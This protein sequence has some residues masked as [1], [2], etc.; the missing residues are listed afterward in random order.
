MAGPWS[1]CFLH[2]ARSTDGYQVPAV[3]AGSCAHQCSEQK[4]Q[5]NVPAVT[6][7]TFCSRE[8]MAGI[9]K[10]NS[11]DDTGREEKKIR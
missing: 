9:E 7:P 5:R 2:P 1:E 3:G 6:E 10:N 11:D 8:E 4:R